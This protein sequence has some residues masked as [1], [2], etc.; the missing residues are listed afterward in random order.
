VYRT[1]GLLDNHSNGQSL[2]PEAQELGFSNPEYS[3]LVAHRQTVA[4]QGVIL[5][6]IR[7]FERDLLMGLSELCARAFAIRG[8]TWLT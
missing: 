4:K 1:T 5:T 6:S 3:S 2:R 8:A 7:K